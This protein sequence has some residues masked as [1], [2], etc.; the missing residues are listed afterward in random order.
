MSKKLMLLSTAGVLYDPQ[1]CPAL[2]DDFAKFLVGTKRVLFIPWALHQKYHDA[3][4]EQTQELI[5]DRIGVEL[6]QIHMEEVPSLEIRDYSAMYIAGG[7]TFRLLNELYKR[8][9]V[10]LIQNRVMS[11]AMRYIGSSAGS[12]V[13][14]PTIKTTNDMPIVWTRSMSA[15]DLVPFQINP[16]YQDPDPNSTHRGETREKRISEFHEENNTAVLG[17]RE[18]S[19]LM[20][21][22]Q[23]CKLHGDKDARLFRKDQSPVE[24][25]PGFDLSF[26]MG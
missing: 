24:C 20:V 25:G 21:D 3:Y 7:N 5:F 22:G 18:G 26:L 6:R 2:L 9:L 8:G 16:H 15:L 23:S 17:L 19:W 1:G 4:T 13:A 11:G 14:C 10:P 12:N